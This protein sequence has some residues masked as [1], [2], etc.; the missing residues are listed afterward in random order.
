MGFPACFQ[1]SVC[2]SACLRV[3]FL[4]NFCL[5][6]CQCDYIRLC[7]CVRCPVLVCLCLCLPRRSSCLQMCLSPKMSALAFNCLAMR[8]PAFLCVFQPGQCISVCLCALP[9]LP[10]RLQACIRAC[11]PG[12]LYACLPTCQPDCLCIYLTT[13]LPAYVS[14]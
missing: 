1:L 7:R 5:S 10:M 12:C 14:T 3:R 8:M 4:W 11:L 9:A 13:C 2:L 6:A